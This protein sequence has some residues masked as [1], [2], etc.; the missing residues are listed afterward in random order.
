[1][2]R[3]A[4]RRKKLEINLN[5]ELQP[6]RIVC[7]NV[8]A[9]ADH[10]PMVRV[11]PEEA[12]VSRLHVVEDVAEVEVHRAAKPLGHLD[13]LGDAQVQVP[14]RHAAEIAAT[15]DLSIQPQNWLADRIA[16]CPKAT[17]W[18]AGIGVAQRVYTGSFSAAVAAKRVEMSADAG[19]H[20]LREDH[21]L[22]RK[23]TRL[24]SSHRC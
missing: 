19:R 4:I 14:K 23:S 1:M 7:L 22:D 10:T 11:I 2:R 6:P 15:P 24:N 8:S 13:F 12:R 20:V 18:T 5:A 21:I 16:E 3:V 9:A 17:D